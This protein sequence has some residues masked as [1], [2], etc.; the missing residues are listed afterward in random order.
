MGV[1]DVVVGDLPC[2]LQEL[3]VEAAERLHEV[4]SDETLSSAAT[5]ERV[6]EL[7][8]ELGRA[9][10]GR[11]LSEKY[12]RH[13]GPQRPCECGQWQKFEGYRATTLMT[14]MGP[15]G[16]QRAYYRCASCR[17]RHYEGDAAVGMLCGRYSLPAQEA[18]ALVCSEVP[19]ESGRELLGRLTGIEVSSSHAQQISGRHGGELEQRAEVERAALFAGELEVLPD[20]RPDR[21]YMAVDGLKMPFRDDW[22]ETKLGAVYD[23][24]AGA[25]GLDE[26]RRV[27]YACGAWEGPEAFGR[28]LYQEAA[29]RGVEGAPEQVAIGDGAP[30]IWNL[31]AEHFPRAVQILDFYHA[32]ERLHQVARAVYGEGTDRARAWAEANADR[33][34]TGRLSDV[35]RSLRGLRPGTAAG[36]EAVRMA[37]GYYQD[38][39]DRMDYPRYRARG[40]H[41]GSGVVE[42][43][44]KTVAAAR[45]K[46]SGM[47]WS[48]QGAQAVL[49]LRSQRLNGRW[50]SYW[51]PLKAAC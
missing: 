4:L 6:V 3:M 25:D 33:L 39:R 28:R 16:Y 20:G 10:L 40:H 31:V 23:V 47:R 27:S 34:W 18:I 48:K 24:R 7:T 44:C 8:R 50:D 15:V 51:Q 9:A 30:W 19:F 12:G 13:Q 17:R 45:C 41:V 38:N 22:H 32:T 2:W 36:R 26:P 37:I 1:H 42:A 11:G 43:A 49:A 5:E 29:H 14:T 21:L 35:L 46:R